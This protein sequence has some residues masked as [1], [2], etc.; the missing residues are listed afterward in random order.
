MTTDTKVQ[1]VK[2]NDQMWVDEELDDE[3]RQ[4]FNKVLPY[5]FNPDFL[6]TGE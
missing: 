4:D 1:F 3:V 5:R 2:I 6:Y